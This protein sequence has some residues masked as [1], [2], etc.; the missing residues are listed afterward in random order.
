VKELNGE[1]R[2]HERGLLHE[3]ALSIGD[4]YCSTRNKMVIVHFAL[5]KCNKEVHFGGA[6]SNVHGV[7]SRCSLYCSRKL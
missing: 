2:G 4:D 3:N 6:K 1:E 7:Y 5:S